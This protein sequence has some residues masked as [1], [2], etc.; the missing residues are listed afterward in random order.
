M[1]GKIQ[2]IGTQLE[3][4]CLD[5]RGNQLSGPIPSEL[6][7]LTTLEELYLEDNLLT[8][9]KTA[10]LSSV[11]FLSRVPAKRWLVGWTCDQ[12]SFPAH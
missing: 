5:L 4:T 6:G 2:G 7:N 11:R 10:T 3:L 8:G 12:G 9:K 1:T